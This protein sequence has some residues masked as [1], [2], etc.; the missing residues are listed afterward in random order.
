[1]LAVVV[2]LIAAVV[3]AYGLYRR[4]TSDAEAAMAD[5]AAR[6]RPA[7]R[8]FDKAM[9]SVLPE[10]AQRYFTH[11]IAPGTPLSSTARL[12]MQGTFLLGDK[13]RFQT[14]E[15]QAR[16][17]LAPPAEFVW[18]PEMKSGPM[19]IS[20]SDALVR[21][22]AWTRFWINGLLPVVNAQASP[23][24]YR[25]ALT[26]AAME[27]IW[28]PASLLPEHGVRWE[29]TGPNTARLFFTTDIEPVDMTLD[30][31]GRV[32]EIVTMRWSDVNPDRTFRLQP[33][34]GTIEVEA[35][36]GG[37]T[38]PS[39]IKVGNHYGTDPYLPFFQVRLI[40]ADYL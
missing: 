13:S 26:R 6:A 11:A 33:F 36:F 7:G 25:S 39:Q 3:V 30:A 27:A 1:M 28:V 12:E 24:L 2:A 35:T 29:Q 9:L 17:I 19:H 22:A 37:F 10:I 23:D 18:I 14:Y 5:V 15:M 40:S 32:I 34:G 38:V 4:A 31:D 20:G 21:G 8:T 16:Q